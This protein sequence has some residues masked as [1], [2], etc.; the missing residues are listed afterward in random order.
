MPLLNLSY[1][2]ASKNQQR[3]D[4][5]WPRDEGAQSQRLAPFC[6]PQLRPSFSIGKDDLVFTIG[7][8]FA[9]NIEQHLVIEGFNVAVSQFEGLCAA[10]GVKVKS[11]TLN[12]FVV[13]SILN[14]LR[15]ALVPGSE[16]P[17]DSLVEVREGRY[18]DMQLAAGL[19]P[20]PK[21][22]MLGMRRAVLNYMKLIK[23]AKVIIITLGLAEA[24]F[25]TEY[26]IYMNSMPLKA[27]ADR[28]G[29]RFKFHLLEY[30]EILSSLR[31]IISVLEEHGHPDFRI[32]LTVSPV[33]L[34]STM[35]LNDAFVANTY[36]KAVQRAAVEQFCLENPRVDYLPTYESITL[37]ERNVAWAEDGA[38]VSDDAVRLNVIRMQQA[39]LD[40]G[41]SGAKD[42]EIANASHGALSEAYKLT[43][44]ADRRAKAGQAVIAEALYSEAAALAPND[45]LIL[46]RW[47]SFLFAQERFEEAE[48][49]LQRSL[50]LGGRKYKV[51]FTLARCLVRL[52]DLQRAVDVLRMAAEDEPDRGSVH[53]LLGKTLTRVGAKS[54][55]KTSLERALELQPKDENIAKLLE[56]V[57]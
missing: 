55:A 53:F 51:A 56:T 19:M 39:Y 47:G 48:K 41:L 30:N 42:D 11:S 34:G 32:L 57:S 54:E 38:H 35:T 7:S 1:S 5:S 18:L 20:A 16:F 37:S 9:R 36:S 25:D 24:W 4:A 52:R 3:P 43:Q 14:E 26:G 31:E 10:E 29:D 15:W 27:T 28:Y 6:R 22:T 17:W 13:Q 33:A 23:D 40:G 21:E 46:V 12:K 49:V 44:I 8:C 50:D 45:V 2:E